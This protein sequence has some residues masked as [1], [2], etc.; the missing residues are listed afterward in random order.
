MFLNVA[1]YHKTLNSNIYGLNVYVMAWKRLAMHARI[2][3][4]LEEL[5]LC[6]FVL[7]FF[8]R[9]Y[10]SCVR[11]PLRDV[12]GRNNP[13]IYLVPP[14][15]KASIRH[16]ELHQPTTTVILIQPQSS[17]LLQHGLQREKRLHRKPLRLT[18][19]HPQ[20]I[21]PRRSVEAPLLPRPG[22]TTQLVYYDPPAGDQHCAFR[23][24]HHRVP[25][26]LDLFWTPTL[27]FG[28]E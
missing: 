10:L 5:R 22:A 26:W 14:E 17:S 1:S 15:L 28:R 12:V 11:T 19:F 3:L 7:R 21:A 18:S 24:V 16:L 23:G 9:Y 4:C 27:I 20:N 25:K 2:R 13:R 8:A 6:W